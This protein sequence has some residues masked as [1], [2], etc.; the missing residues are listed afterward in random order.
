MTEP[1]EVN[2]AKLAQVI[3]DIAAIADQ[4]DTIAAAG[5]A[6]VA[7]GAAAWGDDR[8]GSKFADGADGFEAGA[9]NIVESTSTLS[10]S[11]GNLSNGILS[12][13]KRSD[14]REQENVDGFGK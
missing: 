11:M 10:T 3:H 12:G 1:I 7:P 2:T 9:T 14:E 13:S 8:F 4:L 5:K 6:A